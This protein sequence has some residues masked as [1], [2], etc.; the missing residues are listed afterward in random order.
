VPRR[1]LE[2]ADKSEEH[3]K[4]LQLSK[5][6]IRVAAYFTE[7][8]PRKL[9]QQKLHEAVMLAEARLERGELPAASEGQE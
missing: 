9:L 6:G 3:A 5:S 2:C 1:T 4:L 7:L 8:P